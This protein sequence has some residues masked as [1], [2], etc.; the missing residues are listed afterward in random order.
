MY[1]YMEQY[2]NAY[3]PVP[4]FAGMELENPLPDSIREFFFVQNRQINLAHR[5]LQLENPVV[6]LFIQ[7]SLGGNK[8][9]RQ[10]ANQRSARNTREA[11]IPR[12]LRV[13]RRDDDRKRGKRGR[14]GGIRSNCPALAGSPSALIRLGA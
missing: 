9:K 1:S 7:F 11:P 2:S 5:F 6:P 13:K 4:K 12:L 10:P 8:W 3:T 14:I